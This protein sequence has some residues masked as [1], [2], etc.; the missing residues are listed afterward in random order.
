MKF[1]KALANGVLSGAV[2]SLLLALLL[3][4]LNAALR[5][6]ARDFALA[7][8]GFF[9]VYG[10]AF[11]LLA[12]VLFFIVQFIAGRP[13]RIRFVSP[14][15]LSV[16]LPVAIA[17]VLALG[18]S[19]IVYF[20]SFF[21]AAAR[22]DFRLQGLLLGIAML[23]VPLA[24]YAA[25]R[26]RKR[27]P[28]FAGAFLLMGAAV[29]ASLEMRAAWT[30]P[31]PPPASGTMGP[32]RLSNRVTLI[33]VDGL[34]LDVLLPLISEGKLPNFSW[35]IENG[36]SGR[37]QTLAPAEVLPLDATLLTGKLP[38]RHRRIS[39][40]RYAFFR[41]EAR[42]E[43]FPRYILFR[44]LQRLGIL[45][46][47]PRPEP[48][49]AR[50]LPGI[51]RD[52]GAS[53]LDSPRP[54][55]GCG[56]PPSA[57]AAKEFGQ[58]FRKEPSGRAD[59]L[60]QALRS[61]ACDFEAEEASFAR[62]AQESPDVVLLR[63]S[64]LNAVQAQFYK[65]SFPQLFGNLPPEE[66]ARYGGVIEKYCQFYDQVLGKVLASRRDDE[67]LVV[68]SPFGIE[69]LPVWRRLLE[70]LLGNP[71]I[72]ASHE[73]APD[74]LI[75]AQGPGV[76][77]GVNVEGVKITDVTPTLLYYLALPVGRDMDGVVQ[78]SLFA[79][80]FTAE[81]P[82]LSIGSYEEVEIRARTL[83]G[84]PEPEAATPV[85]PA[86]AKTAP[87]K[88]PPGKPAAAPAA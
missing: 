51:L 83:V 80:E 33:E 30:R 5:L 79:P 42:P 10:T 72:S 21:D 40:W 2:L 13:F 9:L 77:H 24:F 17:L 82:V 3:F 18:R 52:N 32:R 19:N 69:P 61:F 6:E 60:A 15:F 20:R 35:L 63:L 39:A 47:E 38:A 78:S 68:V 58:T 87:V 43:V 54:G 48:L 64:G 26:T 71:E 1:L 65:Y 28:F 84:P 57:R 25:A 76:R 11:A 27:A 67:L 49:L 23:V 55:P 22:R 4:D 8:A 31:S 46:V 73:D 56:E 7:A 29:A 50:D 59:P 85:D 16:S 34:T 66:I 37:M 74:G 14:S 88:A 62:R 12:T 81:Y 53:V 75:I 36:A 44:Q 70:S 45:R 86:P 41:M